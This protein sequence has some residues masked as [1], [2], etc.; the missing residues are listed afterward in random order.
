MRL[1]SA[2]ESVN[3]RAVEDKVKAWLHQARDRSIDYRLTIPTRADVQI[4]V[5]K[6][7]TFNDVY[8]AQNEANYKD[9]L[10]N[11]MAQQTNWQAIY[12]SIFVMK[13]HQCGLLI[14][15]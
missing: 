9:L 7:T 11:K 12:M 15:F 1:S 3:N 4:L 8:L 14:N 5:G 13:T 2:T 6:S 10:F